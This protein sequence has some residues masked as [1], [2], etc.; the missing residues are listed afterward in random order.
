MNLERIDKLIGTLVLLMFNDMRIAKKSW[1]DERNNTVDY[2]ELKDNILRDDYFLPNISICVTLLTDSFMRAF[3]DKLLISIKKV[4]SDTAVVDVDS[5]FIA[6]K[7]GPLSGKHLKEVTK[8]L[9]SHT[10]RNSLKNSVYKKFSRK[11][12]VPDSERRRN[13]GMEKND[14]EG[15]V[16]EIEATFE[17]IMD[18]LIERDRKGRLPIN[19]T[20]DMDLD[21]ILSKPKIEMDLDF[22][23]PY[24]AM[25]YPA[26]A[27][28]DKEDYELI[29]LVY[30]FVTETINLL[31]ESLDSLITDI[32][33]NVTND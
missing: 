2:I 5:S 33:N 20:T 30:P 26:L 22:S 19:D 29:E 17:D 27:S 12:I 7:L 15:A 31:A 9:A 1:Y 24:N 25:L 11:G 14:F 8:I 6:E 23:L 3:G 4:S 28:L 16:S 13:M 32:K 21:Y 18:E 10:L